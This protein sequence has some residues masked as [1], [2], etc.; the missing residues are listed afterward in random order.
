[1]YIY[2]YFTYD[3]VTIHIYSGFHSIWPKTPI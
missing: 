1:M 2:I 3:L